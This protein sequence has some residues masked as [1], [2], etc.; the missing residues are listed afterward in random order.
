VATVKTP[1][2]QLHHS[3]LVAELNHEGDCGTGDPEREVRGP[4]PEVGELKREVDAQSAEI[5]QLRERLPQPAQAGNG[6]G[7]LR[8]AA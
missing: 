8:S 3:N 7:N 1:Q 6:N 5:R 4:R 2:K